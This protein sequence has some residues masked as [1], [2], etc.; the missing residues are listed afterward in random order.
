MENALM[1][2]LR[3]L[4]VLRHAKSDRPDGTLADFDRRLSERGRRDAQRI[5]AWLAA[6][7][8]P[9]RVVCSPARRTVETWE[10]V[11][12]VLASPVPAMLCEAIY[13]AS[14]E[15]LLATIRSTEETVSPLMLI[16]HNPGVHMLALSLI[17]APEGHLRTKYPTGGLATIV[18][19]AAS[20]ADVEKGSGSIE[21]FVAP[22]DLG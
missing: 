7:E 5:G 2:G 16:G 17:D 6:R 12:D 15:A 1:G 18:L 8:P 21:D 14:P 9:G 4:Y 3:K 22:R 20:W 19:K 10:I 11:R 13:L